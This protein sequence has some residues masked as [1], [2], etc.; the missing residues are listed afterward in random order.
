[1]AMR[2]LIYLLVFVVGFAGGSLF[3]SYSL[4]YKQ[5]VLAQFDQA[6]M[7]LGPFQEIANRHHDGSMASLIQHHLNSEDPTFYEEGLAIQMMVD[8]HAQLAAAAT[9]LE[10]SFVDQLQY[11][12][13]HNE[14]ALAAD[15]RATYTPVLVPTTDAMIFAAV[16][17]GA[18]CLLAFVSMRASRS[19]VRLVLR[20]N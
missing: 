2:T 6:A 19:A 18:L 12:A 16:S 1:M 17:G 7:D 9:A 10:G 15:T 20:K 3:P 4:H 5:R 14:D 11:L 8:N 13:A